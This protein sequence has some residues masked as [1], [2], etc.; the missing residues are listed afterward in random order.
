MPAAL[1]R[2]CSRASLLLVRVPGPAPAREEA[3]ATTRPPQRASA[4]APEAVIPAQRGVVLDVFG[5]TLHGPHRNRRRN[6]DRAPRK[7][8]TGEQVGTSSVVLVVAISWLMTVT[9][10]CVEV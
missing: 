3:P 2:E 8:Q 5:R 4:H 7:V 1:A 9:P 6:E 10:S